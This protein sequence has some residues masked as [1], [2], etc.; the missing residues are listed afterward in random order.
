VPAIYRRF[1][2]RTAFIPRGIITSLFQLKQANTKIM[3]HPGFGIP[4]GNLIKILGNHP[5][6]V[7]SVT[8][9]LSDARVKPET[10]SLKTAII[11]GRF[12]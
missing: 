6:G 8:R 4:A 10:Q 9:Q 1:Q 2:N 11:K 12:L 7:P 5:F 3:R